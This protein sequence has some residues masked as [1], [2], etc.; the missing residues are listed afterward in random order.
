MDGSAVQLDGCDFDNSLH[1]LMYQRG[2]SILTF[3]V[4]EKG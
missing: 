3:G 4:L 2:P 1:L